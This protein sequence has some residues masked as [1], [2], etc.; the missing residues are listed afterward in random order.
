[1]KENLFLDV[2]YRKQLSMK[3]ALIFGSQG[4]DGIYLTELLLEKGY[5]V[6]GQYRL[7][8]GDSSL[9]PQLP[10]LLIGNSNYNL[11]EGS[12]KDAEFTH[13]LVR[14]LQ[15]DEIYY[16]A[17]NHELDF[18]LENYEKSRAVNFDGLTGAL[19]ALATSVKKG[20]LFYASSSNIFFNTKETPQNEETP[21]CPSTMYG[22]FK[23]TSMSLIG[24]YREKFGVFA[25]SGIMYNHESPR[26]K[27]FFLPK[28][29]VATA[30][31]IKQ[32]RIQNLCIGNIKSERD[33]GYAGDFVRAMWMILQAQDANDYVI[34]TGVTHSVEWVIN[35]VFE[36][37]GL[38]WRQHVTIRP[39]LIRNFEPN[40]LKAD[41]TKINSQLGWSPEINFANVLKMMIKEELSKY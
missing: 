12:I 19:S 28:K 29:I 41:I 9:R 25:C 33:W 10:P 1:M 37:L 15:P 36:D 27:D 16:L 17:S 31:A 20:R 7:Q 2:R 30:V 11:V 38:D 34:G 5:R 22:F 21:H 39:E 14:D 40:I 23:S 32:G 26:R 3:S 24:M 35:H 6:H 18:S 8:Y 13:N 4:Q